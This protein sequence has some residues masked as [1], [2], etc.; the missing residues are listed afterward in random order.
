MQLSALFFAFLVAVVAKDN[1]QVTE[2]VKASETGPVDRPIKEHQFE[3]DSSSTSDE[4]K[5]LSETNDEM[6]EEDSVS[7]S[8]SDDSSS[9]DNT[10]F[11]NDMTLGELAS[12]VLQGKAVP[13]FL[14]G[15]NLARLPTVKLG[16]ATANYE[17][18]TPRVP[19]AFTFDG[20]PTAG[21]N[22][23]LEEIDNSLKYEG[24]VP[25]VSRPDGESGQ[26][27]LVGGWTRY[28]LPV[29][30]PADGT[31]QL[32]LKYSQVGTPEKDVH[33]LNVVIKVDPNAKEIRQV[34]STL[35][36][37]SEDPVMIPLGDNKPTGE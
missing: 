21:Y 25:I 15:I 13:D 3:E 32:R 35:D 11:P 16:T 24:P 23:V 1:A 6:T 34:K 17:I 10:P 28:V 2:A 27:R 36:G 18:V 20:I 5:G 14:S 31:Y 33:S 9:T 7:S 30:P 29:L 12:Q 37:V 8:E 4:A 26:P 19:F 22:W